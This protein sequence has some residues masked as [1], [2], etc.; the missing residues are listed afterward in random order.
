M[1]EEL[2][3]KPKLKPILDEAYFLLIKVEEKI[4]REKFDK[5]SLKDLKMRNK[6]LLQKEIGFQKT[7]F[8][9]YKEKKANDT[10]EEA[11]KRKEFEEQEGAKMKRLEDKQRQKD[12]VQKE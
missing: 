5:S 2:F 6:K 7:E 11:K 12:E 9:L 4:A 8:K 10:K 1:K 3:E